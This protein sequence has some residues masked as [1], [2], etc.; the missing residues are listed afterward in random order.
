MNVDLRRAYEA[1][2]TAAAHGH[3][4]ALR[5]MAVQDL[6]GGR[7]FLWMPIGL[8]EFVVALCWGTAV[9]MFNKDSDLLRG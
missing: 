7:G 9:S 1:L 8:V 2:K 4:Y 3:A 5:E 6:Q